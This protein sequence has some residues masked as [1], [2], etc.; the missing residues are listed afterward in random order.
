MKLLSPFLKVSQNHLR[1]S[2]SIARAQK[3]KSVQGCCCLVISSANL[4]IL[5]SYA[6]LKPSS[7]LLSQN[8]H[9]HTHTHTRTAPSMRSYPFLPV[10]LW[11]L[12]LKFPAPVK[13]KLWAKKKR[14]SWKRKQRPGYICWHFPA[15][16]F[17][18]WL[19]HP[20]K[21]SWGILLLCIH[22]SPGPPAQHRH[23]G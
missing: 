9:M 8:T 7:L 3:V 16:G 17:P 1:F 14:R 2:T 22:G 12:P 21:E 5:N 19:S 6:L 20:S 18:S 11:H 23:K 15:W 4:K 13:W 10:P